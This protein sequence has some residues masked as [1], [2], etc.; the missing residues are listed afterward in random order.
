[1]TPLE[2]ITDGV[3]GHFENDDS[4]RSSK[5]PLKLCHQHCPMLQNLR[6]PRFMRNSMIMASCC[7]QLDDNDVMLV[8]SASCFN[9][10]HHKPYDDV[11]Q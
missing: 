2:D 9:L 5:D 4:E 10:W 3:S 1:M 8:S 6:P 11:S 7:A